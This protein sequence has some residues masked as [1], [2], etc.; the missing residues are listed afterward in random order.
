MSPRQRSSYPPPEQLPATD[1]VLGS[2]S[3]RALLYLANIAVR[4]GVP[5]PTDAALR[6][7]LREQGLLSVRPLSAK[8]LVAEL[9]EA[10]AAADTL[11]VAGLLER[12]QRTPHA[13]DEV[14]ELLEACRLPGLTHAIF[15]SALVVGS[16]RS[17]SWV[18][19]RPEPTEPRL[20]MLWIEG[21]IRRGQCQRAAEL[22]EGEPREGFSV[23]LF[24]EALCGAGDPARS[25]EVLEGFRPVSK[26]ERIQR[27][28]RLARALFHGNRS[29][30]AQALLERVE[31]EIRRTDEIPTARVEV[32][33]SRVAALRV[34]LG[35]LHSRPSD[36]GSD[37]SRVDRFFHVDRAIVRGIRLFA[38]GSFQRSAELFRT[39]RRQA[40]LPA[41]S[42]L[43]VDVVQGV[44]RVARGR[45]TGLPGTARTMTLDAERLGNAT[46]Y[47]WAYLLER[48]VTLS[49]AAEHPE[50]PWAPSIPEPTG[51]IS[52][53]LAAL[54]VSHRARRG[55]SV[56]DEMLP[57]AAP[58]DGPFVACV[59]DLTE[60]NVLLLRG[61]GEAAATL[62]RQVTQRTV[63]SGYGLFEGEALLIECYA[64][65]H[66]RELERLRE[67][68]EA[69]DATANTLRSKRYQ[70]LAELMNG[71]F[72]RQ[73]DLATLLRLA[74]SESASPTAA[75]VAQCLLDGAP[76]R[77]ALDRTIAEGVSHGWTSRVESLGGPAAWVCDCVERIVYLPDR[78]IAISPLSARFLARLF[79]AGGA[80][81]LEDAAREVW[82]I[83]DYHP[84]RDSKRVHVAVRRLRK[85]IEDDPSTPVRLV[86]TA[87]GYRLGVEAPAGIL[88]PHE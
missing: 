68:L 62:A 6:S 80:C 70:T 46:L 50:P 35:L 72:H 22:L 30:E 25:I 33:L 75:R 12:W 66:L 74:K 79:G 4:Q 27:D 17:L 73:P 82:D 39:V 31:G 36:D 37:R 1:G 86:T 28:L 29:A 87:E 63:S 45:Y 2:L 55:E 49:N 7:E 76:V 44:L 58:G 38:A 52:R 3:R 65:L 24:G 18:V 11:A 23:L 41:E 32:L 81:T 40:D 77:D 54:R 64:R 16:R 20:R 19:E 60:A 57:K 67:T 21:M 9:R 53:Y 34:Q 71:A 14:W 42:N 47:H 56:A 84:L 78:T 69:L 59:C 83:D 48:L 61:N 15:R 26:T 43:L 85:Q 10:I 5:V 8:G 13:A 51:I 88:L